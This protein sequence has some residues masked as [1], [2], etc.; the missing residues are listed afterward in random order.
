MPS[1]GHG[2]V[3]GTNPV[4]YLSAAPPSEGI[5][6]PVNTRRPGG[7]ELSLAVSVRLG[8]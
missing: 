8:R 4:S 5:Q 1:L 3:F 7:V 2:L 6:A